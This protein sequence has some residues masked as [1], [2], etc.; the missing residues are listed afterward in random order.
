MFVNSRSEEARL[1]YIMKNICIDKK[2][3][4]DVGANT[5]YFSFE[6]LK[7]G[8]E[9]VT[10]YEGNFE[11]ALFLLNSSNLLKV[12]EKLNIYNKYYDFE[13]IN[14]DNKYDVMLL[15]NV[16]HHVGDDYGDK[17]LN[18]ENA[19]QKILQQLN[20]CAS[21]AKT[22]VFQLGFN[23]KG[24]RNVCLFEYGTKEELIDFIKKG[25]Q[26]F[27]EI[28]QIGIAEKYYDTIKYNDLNDSNIVRQDSLGEFLNRP[29]FIMKS[30]VI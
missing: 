16:F 7:Q 4:I 19:K 25:T 13:N 6:L 21:I 17:S 24:N 15:L 23:W 26:E 12:T 11:H 14:T 29:I 8:A 20:S 27:W 1:D 9:H 10:C 5:G 2:T 28:E 18:I 3:I 30:R 22:I